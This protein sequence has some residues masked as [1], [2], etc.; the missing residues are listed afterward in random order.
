MDHDT[1]FRGDL[2]VALPDDGTPRIVLVVDRVDRSHAEVALVHSAPELATS[3]DVI[4]DP[5][6]VTVTWPV[7]VQ[8]YLRG[9]APVHRLL[10]RVGSVTLPLDGRRGIPIGGPTTDR[11]WQFK[12]AEGAALSAV[13]LGLDDIAS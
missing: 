1:P 8:G 13:T 5:A 10:Q 9:V 11:R 12:Q 6:T 7:V 2:W 3:A 4:C